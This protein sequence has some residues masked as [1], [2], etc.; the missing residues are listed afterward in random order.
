MRG[1]VLSNGL[2]QLFREL[3]SM[4]AVSNNDI[5]N[6]AKDYFKAQLSKS[7]ELALLLPTDPYTDIDFEITGTQQLATNMREALKQ[8]HFS[9]SVQL[10]ARSLLN[11]TNPDADTM[12][13]DAFQFACHA[14]LRA[15]I[16]STRILAAQLSGEYHATAPQ[17]PWFAGIAAVDLPPIPG[18]KVEAAPAGPTFGMIAKQ[19]FD[20]KSKN[21]WVAKTAADVKRVIALATELIGPDKPMA[22]I[23]IEDVKRVR[24]ALASLP[25]NYLKMSAN[26]SA[27][28]QQ[29]ISA[30]VSGASL[31]VKTQDKY[32]TMFKQILIWA[33]NEGYLD[34]VPGAN[35][36]VA[37]LKK[38][39]PGEQRDP[40]SPDQ[41]IKIMK[42][43]LYTGHK[44]E[45]CRHKPGTLVIRDGYFWTPLI[46]LFSGMRL[47]E[48]LQLQKADVKLENVVWFFDICKGEEKSL[49]TASSKRR[50]PV[51]QTLVALGFL[52][53]AKACPAGRLFPE[54][55]K[56][57]D[58]YHSHNFS[59]WWRRF[60]VHVGFK[61]SR[62]AFHSFRHNFLD[63]LRAAETPEYV[64]KALAGH[65]D[66]SVH[67]QYGGG[68]MLSQLKT[69]IDKVSYAIDF[70]EL[71]NSELQ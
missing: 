58:G 67:S 52:D 38:I 45:D 8:Q 65:S 22:L 35:V 3:R 43:P 9:P 69:A 27:N 17:D 51:H 66:N 10:D 30:N 20:F 18:D 29:A 6:R 14:V 23:D 70:A 47:G 55:K 48:I 31:S 39:V 54:I 33:A 59:K 50:V 11:P 26:K 7:L 64:N 53:Y 34:K 1:R 21:D 40:Y 42:S 36:K 68:A 41:L 63:A 56:G 61:S 25:P 49:K 4:S 28:A 62:T 60:A 19:F 32:Y 24:D 15:K 13:S 16:E 71:W 37:G 5:V 46:A 2:E 12:P 57:N 44:S